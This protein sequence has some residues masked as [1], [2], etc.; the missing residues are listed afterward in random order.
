MQTPVSALWAQVLAAQK[1][2]RPA[3]PVLDRPL[4]TLLAV[5]REQAT[6]MPPDAQMCLVRFPT[7]AV[8]TLASVVPFLLPVAFPVLIL[9]RLVYRHP[10]YW[11]VS[12]PTA[13]QRTPQ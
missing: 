9:F 11:L 2:P 10:V 6:A 3:V 8:R 12:A 5:L 1:Y 7:S 13:Q 4:P